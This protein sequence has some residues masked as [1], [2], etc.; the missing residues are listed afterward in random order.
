MAKLLRKRTFAK[1]GKPARGSL[2]LGYARVSKGDEQTNA[3]QARALRAAGCRRIF[4]EVASGG[5]WDRPEL[6][7]MLD[8]LR[9]GDTGARPRWPCDGPPPPCRK[10]SRASVD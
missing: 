2:L 4:E 6:H 5:R 10:L 1:A 8:H 3:L 9:E 7:G